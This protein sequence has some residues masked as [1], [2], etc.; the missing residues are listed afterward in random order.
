MVSVNP[1]PAQ[2]FYFID[3]MNM[4]L[5]GLNSLPPAN[6]VTPPHPLPATSMS[7]SSAGNTTAYSEDPSKKIRKPYIITKSRESWTDQ[8]HDKFLEALQLSVN[9]SNLIHFFSL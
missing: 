8:E 7:T 1:N 4:G 9:L 6:T 3:P 2:G 5:P